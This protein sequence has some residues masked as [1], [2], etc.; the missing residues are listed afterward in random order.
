MFVNYFLKIRTF[1]VHCPDKY[2]SCYTRIPCYKLSYNFVTAVADIGVCQGRSVSGKGYVGVLARGMLD[3]S[4][5]DLWVLDVG[6]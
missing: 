2:S 5:L 4:V 6:C 3:T 1:S